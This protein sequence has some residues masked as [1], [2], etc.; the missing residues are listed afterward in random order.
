MVVVIAVIAL[1]LCVLLPAMSSLS[2]SSGRKA[3]ING[4][5]GVLEQARTLAIKDG[6]STYVLFPT[7]STGSAAT[8]D[9]YNFKSYAI[10]EDLPSP[11][12]SPSATS[13]QVGGWKT[14]PSGIAL[15]ASTG[16]LNALTNL[17]KSSAL[18]PPF[19]PTF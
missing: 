7:F 12:P 18:N 17:P 1:L 16:H 14:L 15:R 9:R 2:K 4:L 8:L 10:F 11:T 19:S 3:A 5:V 13:K 6:V